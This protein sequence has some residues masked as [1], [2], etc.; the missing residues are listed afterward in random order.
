MSSLTDVEAL[1]DN[2]DEPDFPLLM[3]LVYA[4]GIA[5]NA[6]MVIMFPTI[7]VYVQSME[8]SY[9]FYGI[10]AASYNIAQALSAP[11]LQKWSNTHSIKE[12]LLFCSFASF[13]GNLLYTLSKG[14]FAFLVIGRL[15]AGIG[16]G[17]L[18][19]T[20][21]Y[22]SQLSKSGPVRE[23]RIATYNLMASITQIVVP[24]IGMIGSLIDK[25]RSSTINEF[26]FPAFFMLLVFG[27]LFLIQ[28]VHFKITYIND[29]PYYPPLIREFY[30]GNDQSQ[31]TPIN[32]EGSIMLLI[33]FFV[34]FSYWTFVAAVFPYGIHHYQWSVRRGYVFFISIGIISAMTF[35]CLRL[36]R[37]KIN[38]AKIF[39]STL[40][41]TS[42]GSFSIFLIDSSNIIHEVQIYI[43]ILFIGC[44]FFL[45]KITGPDLFSKIV[46]KN[47]EELGWFFAIH[48]L[49]RC[50]GPFAGA[51]IVDHG[52]KF[53][54]VVINFLVL[55]TMFV[56]V[57]YP[58]ELV[59][60]RYK[61]SLD[62]PT[63]TKTVGLK[64]P[65]LTY[66]NVDNVEPSWI[67]KDRKKPSKGKTSNKE[68]LSADEI[69]RN[70]FFN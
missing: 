15:I 35:V 54:G 56:L 68:A 30:F 2:M 62:N 8:Y 14:R 16:G 23:K 7:V 32:L 20:H 55:V 28:C 6:D 4:V 36:M 53:T 34:I 21:L 50:T 51:I 58:F 33:S 41:F 52:L 66:D 22:I 43:A 49:A 45:N 60:P 59:F 44:S 40:V 47:Q 67:K 46:N 25:D 3:Y 12:S 18:F 69:E 63:N 9:I 48:C 70:N 29:E 57:M 31:E 39:T 64:V 37:Q 19:S 38:P 13:V 26:V 65:L 11:L 1:A 10:A 5:G 17:A 27:V 42:I 24:G 61:F